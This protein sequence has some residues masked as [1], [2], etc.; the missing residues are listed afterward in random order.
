M[1]AKHLLMFGLGFMLLSGIFSTVEMY[2]TKE[3]KTKGEQAVALEKQKVKLTDEQQAD[4]AKWIGYQEKTSVA[5]LKKEADKEKKG[6]LQG[7]FGVMGHETD[8]SMMMESTI[9]YRILFL[10]VLTFLFIGMAL[11]KWGV[12][13]GARSKNFYWATLIIGYGLGLTLSYFILHTIAS[14]RFDRIKTFDILHFDFYQERRILL[15]LAHLSVIMLLYKYGVAKALLRGL[16]KVGQMAFS[17]YLMQSIFCAIIFYG[18][19]FGLFGKLQRYQEYYVVFAIWVFQIIFSNI[20]L[21]YFKF[22]PFEW[23]WRSLTYWKKQPM[24]KTIA[25]EDMEEDKGGEEMP[26]PALA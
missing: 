11:F 13:T 10:D 23:V 17:N 18:F 4:K 5:S 2:H 8:F 12:L 9:M 26:M 21:H 22:G 24:K 1:K 20:W 19:G 15:A 14:T 25:V 16:S 7:Y 6:Y 3:I